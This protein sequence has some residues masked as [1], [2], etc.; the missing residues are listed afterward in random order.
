VSA[1]HV[2]LERGLCLRQ[3]DDGTA[4]VLHRLHD[5]RE[6]TR[7]RSPAPQYA[8][9]RF[10]PDGTVRVYQ[11][12]VDRVRRRNWDPRNG[13]WSAPSEA[14]RGFDRAWDWSTF[15]ERM[16]I[17]R[18]ADAA[19]TVLDGESLREVR[20]FPLSPQMSDWMGTWQ[21]QYQVGVSADGKT[22]AY[23]G[24][25]YG[26]A[27]TRLVH[28][29]DV[30]TGKERAPLEHDGGLNTLV[31]LAHG[32]LATSC[33]DT[34]VIRIWDVG[35]EP[36]RVVA[37]LD[38]QKGGAPF[39][40]TNP[41]GD[42]LVST[43]AWT[44]GVRIW[45]PRTAQ[46]LLHVPGSRL[47]F[48]YPST[49]G[50]VAAH[51]DS[52]RGTTPRVWEVVPTPACQTFTRAPGAG[53]QDFRDVSVSPDWRLIAVGVT[54]GVAIWDAVSGEQKAVIRL[55]ARGTPYFAPYSSDLFTNGSDGLFR[56]PHQEA[57]CDE[58][59]R[60]GP[61][62]RWGDPGN[63]D[64]SISGSRDGKTL[65][66]SSWLD[67]IVYEVGPP[68]RARTIAPHKDAH[69]HLSPDGRILAT[70]GHAGVVKLWDVRSGELLRELP[71]G[72]ASTVQFSRDGRKLLTVTSGS[73][74]LWEVSTGLQLWR[75]S[76][77]GF[78][79]ALS[80][81]DGL[82]VAGSD[83]RLCLIS[84]ATGRTLARL[85]DP[86][87]GRTDYLTFSPDGGKI[88][89]VSNDNQALHVWDLRLIRRQLAEMG[90]D[91]DGPPLPPAP[92][93]PPPVQAVEVVPE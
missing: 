19:L 75:S 35:V 38:R 83:R 6:V 10:Q 41:A 28:L 47:H 67:Q 62:E 50:G 26:K 32:P 51:E 29:C 91:W 43:A 73:C 81:D 27:M 46:E 12:E 70:A 68:R 9:R 17:Y 20:S 33:I 87:R 40:S 90:L 77:G 72:T 82:A 52:S 78:P 84:A 61:P 42:L 13:V 66:V 31:W 53:P 2:D 21:A 60:F 14:I 48:F 30:D 11:D 55:R 64:Y 54:E 8:V 44:G 18:E 63:I 24:G 93:V 16:L 76:A 80:P 34:N 5:N 22:V 15:G 1:L 71:R 59:V 92:K 57:L 25:P 89:T 49:G 37:V 23:C 45:H 7:S 56:W 69:S 36:A 74:A 88:V 58:G 65:V 85:E 39:L 4:L 86:R 3:A 79:A